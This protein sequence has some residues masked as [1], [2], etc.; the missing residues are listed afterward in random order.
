MGK[1][2]RTRPK[3]VEP[4]AAPSALTK[5]GN[6]ILWLILSVTFVTFF[7]TLFN[8]FAYDDREFILKNQIVKSSSLG[9]AVS[10]IPM[11]LTKELWFYRALQ[12]KDPNNAEPTTPYYRPTFSIFQMICWQLFQD[13]AGWWHLT[14]VLVHL[15]AVYFVFLIVERIT[16]DRKLSAITSLLFA[17]HPLRVESVAW[18]CGISDP[19]LAVLLLSSLYLYMR[20]RE[21]GKAKLLIGSLALFLLAV[22]A[23]EPAVALPVFIVAYELFVANRENS[24]RERL[25]FAVIG[26]SSFL[27]VAASYFAAR[28][29]ALG[30]VLNNTN[31]KS[32]PLSQIV[33]TIPLVIW[34]YI[35]LLF[36]PVDL[37]LFHAT[38]MVKSPADLQF[39]LPLG[40]LAALAYGL[41]M[42]RKSIAARFGI[43]WFAINLFPVL[44]LSAFGEEFLVQER[45]VYVPSIGFSLLIAMALVRIPVERWLPLGSRRTAQAALVGLLVLLLAGKSV[46]QN[47]VWK[48]DLA[49]WLHGAETAPEQSMSH[50]I[51]GHK[52]IARG[53]YGNGDYQNAARQLEEYLKLSPDNVIAMANLASAYSL[54]YQYQVAT[55][56]DRADPAPLTRAMELCQRGLSISDKTSALWDTMGMIYTYKTNQMN[57]DN[58]IACFQRGLNVEDEAEA[59]GV[60]QAK[61]P[62]IRFHLG[63]TLVKKED[64]DGAIHYLQAALQQNAEFIDAHK[65]LAYAYKGK[66][67]VKEA[68][69]EFGIYLQLQPNALDGSRVSKEIQDLRAQLQKPSPQS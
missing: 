47:T 16:K 55:N 39:I 10:K 60:H 45:Y 69:N 13:N 66:G 58:A 56:P 64:Y 25:R 19:F 9:E 29:Y 31:F 67:Q 57:L 28:Y 46:A 6:W 43:L 26:G 24:F 49:V 14:N 15:L 3:K 36:W 54:I 21:E 51:L 2:K 38:Y 27:V 37:S 18:I 42:L 61:N 59:S 62:A 34:K 40:G 63:A 65:F 50:Y 20:C 7:N 44:N 12:D 33:L 23:K 17:I 41:W 32:Y 35:G 1:K 5:P 11:V 8:G 53:D 4:A 30:F 22:F 68:I 52:L 48:D